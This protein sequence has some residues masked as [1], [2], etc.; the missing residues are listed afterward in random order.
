[1]SCRAFGDARPQLGPGA[2]VDDTA[3]VIGRV[4]LG[5]DSSVWP[6]CVLRG[7][8]NSIRIGAR[9][10]IQD[11]SVLHVNQPTEAEPDGAPLQVGDDVTVGHKVI[12]HGCTIE[13]GTLIGMGAVVLDRARVCSGAL[14]AAGALVTPGKTLEGGWLWA[15]QPARAVR[16]LNAGERAMIAHSAAH[17]VRLAARYR[18]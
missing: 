14:V 8:V 3:V 5:A 12:L 4:N 7:D 10:N 18:G 6:L 13:D 9:T 1:M 15:G 17:Y 16:E 2:W 11:G